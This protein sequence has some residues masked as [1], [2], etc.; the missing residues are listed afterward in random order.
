[1][2][3]KFVPMICPQCGSQ[4]D[5][6]VDKDMCFCAACGTKI[7]IND[8]SI[9]TININQRVTDD[10]RIAEAQAKAKVAQG[11][12]NTILKAIVI[13]AVFVLDIIIFMVVLSSR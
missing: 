13:V 10:A 11:R 12:Q 1:M 6:P 9:K 3:I 7:L 4:M 8:D 5:V 2:P